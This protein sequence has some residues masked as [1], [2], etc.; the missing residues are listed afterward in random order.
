MALYE[1]LQAQEAEAGPVPATPKTLVEKTVERQ[2]AQDS[3][4]S[5]VVSPEMLAEMR[6]RIVARSSRVALGA[7]ARRG[8]TSLVDDDP[9]AH[10]QRGAGR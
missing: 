2:P 5:A 8:P 10:Q 3:S 4:A 6:R 1:H 9:S 7:M